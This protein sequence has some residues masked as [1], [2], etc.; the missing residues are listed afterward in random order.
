MDKNDGPNVFDARERYLGS[1][2][3]VGNFH[4]SAYHLEGTGKRWPALACRPGSTPE[5]EDSH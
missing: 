2:R 1:R 5:T 3:V 4:S